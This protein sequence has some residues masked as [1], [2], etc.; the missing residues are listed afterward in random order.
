MINM[1][2]DNINN[3]VI[4]VEG[5]IRIKQALLKE[6]IQEK[7]QL[8]TLDKNFYQ[9][10]KDIVDTEMTSMLH[11]L[12]RI[13]HAKIILLSNGIF[14][15]NQASKLTCEELQLYATLCAA[16]T[17]HRNGEINI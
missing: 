4:N 13:R 5:V 9:D 2:I 15:S 8:S 16:N 11:T 10:Y 1:M 14:D 17:K 7:W 6:T 3:N 12:I